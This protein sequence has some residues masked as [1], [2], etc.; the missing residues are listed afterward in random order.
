MRRRFNSLDRTAAVLGALLIVLAAL[1]A[2]LRAEGASP[3]A[4][5]SAA[6]SP[7]ASPLA[8]PQSKVSE[9]AAALAKVQTLLEF[10][11]METGSYPD[12]LEDMLVQYNQGVRQNETPV[13]Y[14]VD[15]ATGR[16]LIYTPS[17]DRSAYTI[18]V[19]EPAA[20]GL[21][22]LSVRNIDWGWMAELAAQQKRKRLLLTCGRYQ[23]LL[24]GVIEQY[25]K[26]H[27]NKY[28]DS[29]QALIPKY[30]KKM[31]VCPVSGKPYIY[32]HDDRGFEV[33]CPDPEAHGLKKFSFGFPGGLQQIPK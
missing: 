25:N 15:P 33:S 5:P 26:D 7:A 24:A 32:T 13:G 9:A 3:A 2:A 14:P 12:T 6:P 8:A 23:E 1:P 4:T 21:S 17:A 18:Q 28:P 11:Y 20:Y 22:A 29:L 10:Y 31:P 30:L 16:H 27:R 19:P